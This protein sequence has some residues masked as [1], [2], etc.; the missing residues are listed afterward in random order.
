MERE[1]SELEMEL[2]NLEIVCYVM[3][4]LEIDVKSKGRAHFVF[5][6][7]EKGAVLGAR[8]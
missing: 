4:Q 3:V 8:S 2:N 6:T 7:E 5:W 1:V